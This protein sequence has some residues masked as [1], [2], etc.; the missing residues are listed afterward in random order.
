MISPIEYRSVIKFF[1]LQKKTSSEIHQ[2]LQATYLQDAPSL[3]TVK[4][5]VN[6]FRGGRTSVFD[7]D[8]EG[9][10]QEIS[11]NVDDKLLKM[12][13]EERR[14]S[15]RALSAAANISI[16]SLHAR[17]TALGVR[18]LC[19]RFVP[20]FL[21]GDMMENRRIACESNIDLW[22]QHGDKFLWNI[23]TEDETPLSTYIP[24]SKRDSAEWKLPGER[25]SLKMRSGTSHRRMLMLS[26]FWDSKGIVHMDFADKSVRINAQYYSDLVATARKKRR[27]QA[28]T[29]LWYLHDNAPVHTAGISQARIEQAGLTPLAHP[30][31]S[32]DL[33]PSDYFLF[34]H[35]KKHLRGQSFTGAADLQCAVEQFFEG[36]T[37]D[38]FKSAFL[39]LLER[40]KKCVERQGSYVEK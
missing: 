26:I 9:R 24:E 28:G 11:D 36:C 10:P 34:R 13:Q 8:R 5:W 29:P 25:P 33:A 22:N 2:M 6:A 20:R 27:R 12:V 15:M 19:S 3:S 16:G 21:S 18:K 23:L 17:M 39:E 40:W 14:I 35:L 31:Y 30:P 38:F 7:D 4:N 1:V 32:P 37:P